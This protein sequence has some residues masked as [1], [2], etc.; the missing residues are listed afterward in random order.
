MGIFSLGQQQSVERIILR[1]TVLVKVLPRHPLN[2]RL[3]LPERDLLLPVVEHGTDGVNALEQLAQITVLVQQLQ[4]RKARIR[5]R[6]EPLVGRD[7][8]RDGRHRGNFRGRHQ[9]GQALQRDGR[10]LRGH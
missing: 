7:L 9:R 1:Q 6:L 4:R 10:F 8:G 5:Q 3:Q 2:R